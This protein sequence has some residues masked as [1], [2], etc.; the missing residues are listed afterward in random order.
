MKNKISALQKWNGGDD[1]IKQVVA[2]IEKQECNRS[3]GCHSRPERI[4]APYRNRK[5]SCA[6]S[7]CRMSNAAYYAQIKNFCFVFLIQKHYPPYK[8]TATGRCDKS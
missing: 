8:L 3:P 1:I 4:T 6:Q 5:G 2:E 7:Y